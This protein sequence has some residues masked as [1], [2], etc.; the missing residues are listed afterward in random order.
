[1]LA[2]APASPL[3]FGDV[4]LQHDGGV[5]DWLHSG[6]GYR[7]FLGRE[8]AR[9]HLPMWM[10]DLLSGVPFLPQIEAGA[11][12]FPDWPIWA[13][14]DATTAT[15]IS[16]A[17]AILVSAFGARGLARCYGMA[18]I[19]ATFTGLVFGMAGFTSP[20]SSITTCTPPPPGSRGRCGA[21]RAA[22]RETCVRGR[23]CR[24]S[25][26]FR[27]SPGTHRSATTQR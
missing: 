11:L 9:G 10:P 17:A 5:S 25:S 27:R 15:A 21:S 8:L 26:R 16:I 7:V 23:H 18:G 20:T 4:L 2:L 3:L 1:L 14:F 12:Y 22:S 19:G 24:S 6:L 13:L